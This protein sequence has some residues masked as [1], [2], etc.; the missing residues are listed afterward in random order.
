MKLH[1]G[2]VF[3]G[4]FLAFKSFASTPNYITTKVLMDMCNDKTTMGQAVCNAY[5]GGYLAGM[6]N[7]ASIAEWKPGVKKPV[8]VLTLRDSVQLLLDEHPA[9]GKGEIGAAT[10]LALIRQGI[11]TP[12][13]K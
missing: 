6:I 5:F 8:S 7:A 1:K 9:I 13:Q 11:L 4:L 3:A 10:T 2:I 12:K